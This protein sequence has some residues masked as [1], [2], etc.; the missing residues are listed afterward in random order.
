MMT[1]NTDN[2]FNGLYAQSYNA[3]YD[4]KDYSG[5][6][7][8]IENFL[9]NYA[10]S[11]THNI[12]DAGC[13]TGNHSIILTKRGYN[14]V[15]VDKS[16]TMI[17]NAQNFASELNVDIDFVQS[18]LRNL[19]LGKKFNACISMFAVLSYMISDTDVNN[20]LKSIRQHLLPGSLFI[21]DFWYGPGVINISPSM[22]VK[23]IEQNESEIY[24]LANPIINQ[25]DHTCKIKFIVIQVKN[26]QV[27]D[28]QI[29]VHNCR[30][31]F[32]DELKSFFHK[33]KFEL[34]SLH[35]FPNI[36]TKPNKNTWNALGI[37]I[38]I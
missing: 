30:Y 29:E 14:M 9:N 16:Q 5:E 1:N 27:Q 19:K 6:C 11:K 2:I 3:F 15:G 8:I 21:F 7:D 24:R 38:A 17:N 23:L 20:Y 4:K 28:S 34:K 26:T 10:T 32:E 37:A 36:S 12:L 18:D 22:R 35:S 13:G 25:N 33:N 31:F